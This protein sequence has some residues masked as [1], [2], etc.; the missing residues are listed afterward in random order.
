MVIYEA[1]MDSGGHGRKATFT[2]IPMLCSCLEHFYSTFF[3]AV[4]Y[5]TKIKMPNEPVDLIPVPSG[6]S[7]E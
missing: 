5:L 2:S 1:E 6:L 4:G 7:A 3:V